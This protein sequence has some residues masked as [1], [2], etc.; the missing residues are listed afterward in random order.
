MAAMGL[1][2]ILPVQTVRME[3]IMSSS[4]T[5]G[6]FAARSDIRARGVEI[7]ISRSRSNTLPGTVAI[8]PGRLAAYIR[9]LV[10]STRLLPES[11]L[12]IEQ[13]PLLLPSKNAPSRTKEEL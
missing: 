11:L 6:C 1:R 3:D 8:L 9:N 12:I 10:K 4:Q 5:S 2:Q 7:Q 13:K